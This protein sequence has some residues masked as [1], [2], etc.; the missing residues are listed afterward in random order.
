MV[1]DHT[2]ASDV[3]LY[4]GFFRYHPGTGGLAVRRF[5]PDGAV[6]VDFLF[7]QPDDGCRER[8]RAW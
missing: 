8:H 7:Q 4:G 5:P 6:T 3:D 2:V 1:F